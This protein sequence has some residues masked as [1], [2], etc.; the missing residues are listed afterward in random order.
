MISVQQTSVYGKLKH[1]DAVL[2]FIRLSDTTG[3]VCHT[4]NDDGHYYYDFQVTGSKEEL[5]VIERFCKLIT[6]EK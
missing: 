3:T 6:D 2:D 1:N 4:N 5:D